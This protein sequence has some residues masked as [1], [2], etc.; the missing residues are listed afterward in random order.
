MKLAFLRSRRSDGETGL[1]G[2]IKSKEK[3]ENKFSEF[4]KKRMEKKLREAEKKYLR[5]FNLSPE[6]IVV[7]DSKGVVLDV[8]RRIFDWLGYKPKE[9]IGK[10]MLK[11]PFMP[12]KSKLVAMKKLERRLRGENLA[13]YNL[14]FTGKTGQPIVGRINAAPIT[15]DSGKIIGDLVMIGNVTG[16]KELEEEIRKAEQKYKLFFEDAN[17]IIQRCDAD[18]NFLE[19]NK[20]WTKVL[21]YSKEEAEELNLKDIIH[22]DYLVQ[23]TDEFK[24]VIFGKKVS[25]IKTVFVSKSGKK[26]HLEVNATPIFGKN[27][28]LESTLGIF[29]VIEKPEK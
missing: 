12:V 5:L 23:C 7:L 9:I 19:V 11:P 18:G 1:D 22:P 13:P 20:K 3:E 14:V 4:E 27:R 15:D 8:N 21:G 24:K 10:N 2:A 26:I 17:D 28:K 29:R 16:S 6:A 25:N